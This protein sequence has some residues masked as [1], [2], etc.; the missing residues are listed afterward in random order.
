MYCAAWH[1]LQHPCL[2]RQPPPKRFT[3]GLSL[4]P[5]PNIMLAES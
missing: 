5:Q 1:A 3:I 2:P 4:Q